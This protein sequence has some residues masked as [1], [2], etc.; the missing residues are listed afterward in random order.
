MMGNNIIMND[1]DKWC[2]LMVYKSKMFLHRTDD[3]A[4]DF[5]LSNFG[6]L[7]LD[8]HAVSYKK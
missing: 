1:G 4:P 7:Y 2:S 8:Q 6:G 5:R 3:F